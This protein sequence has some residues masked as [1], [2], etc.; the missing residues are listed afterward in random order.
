M[1]WQDRWGKDVLSSV[2]GQVSN[3]PIGAHVVEEYLTEVRARELVSPVLEQAQVDD[4]VA[5][6]LRHGDLG[7]ETDRR[8][9]KATPPQVD[10]DG[11]LARFPVV[12]TG[13]PVTVEVKAC[14]AICGQEPISCQGLDLRQEGDQERVQ[15][16]IAP[17]A[18]GMRYLRVP[19]KLAAP[20][21]HE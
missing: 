20:L 12:M 21:T 18:K 7:S 8:G 6:L 10:R 1:V 16:G 19:S 11:H 3:L 15:G 17:E 2:E 14:I 4:R 5:R 13:K 9:R